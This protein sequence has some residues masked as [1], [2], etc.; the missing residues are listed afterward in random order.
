MR[1]GAAV[2]WGERGEGIGGVSATACAVGLVLRGVTV[3]EI[4]AREP[5]TTPEWA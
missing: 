4:Y 3:R 5:L 2:A 1:V